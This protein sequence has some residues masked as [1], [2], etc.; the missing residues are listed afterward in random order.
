MWT[1]EIDPLFGYYRAM[2]VAFLKRLV[3]SG[4]LKHSGIFFFITA[5]EATY[6]SELAKQM[7][8]SGTPLTSHSHKRPIQQEVILSPDFHFIENEGYHSLISEMQNSGKKW[9]MRVKKVFWRGSTTGPGPCEENLRVRACAAARSA[10]W[11]DVRVSKLL[12]FCDQSH[13]PAVSHLL[14]PHVHE[15]NWTNYRGILD[16]DGNVNA[17]GLFWRLASESVV[18]RVES[19]Y[20]NSYSLAMKPWVHYI[21]IMRNLSDLLDKT[22]LITSTSVVDTARL[23]SIQRRAKILTLKFTYDRVL[24][25]FAS[26]L[27]LCWTRWNASLTP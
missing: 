2:Q 8:L 21:P 26:S 25:R 20:V 17:W 4:Y 9:H 18:F 14:S 1:S 15:S 12:Q 11:C 5:D 10:A 6:P 13:V 19:E 23:F 3:T 22:G 16:I 7:Y 27:E 24:E